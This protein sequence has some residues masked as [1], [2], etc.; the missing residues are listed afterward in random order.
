MIVR[1]VAQ[2]WTVVF[3]T[4]H[5]LLAQRIAS[6]LK[7]AR[8]LPFWFETQVAIGLHDDLHRVYE[9]G[10][11]EQLTE[12]GAPR[13]F[14]LVSM[15]DDERADETQAHIDEAFRKHSWL[16]VMQSKH[17]D[18]LYRG[19]DT[20]AEMQQLLDAEAKRREA[21]LARLRIE[22]SLVQDTYDWMHFC[23]RF[24][25][26]LCGNDVPAMHRRLEIITNHGGTRFELWQDDTDCIRVAPWPFVDETVELSVEYRTL[27]QLSYADDDELGKALKACPVE[28][29]TI[30]M[31]NGAS[32][33]AD[34]A[35]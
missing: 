17:A 9:K 21:T 22:P 27:R 1:S 35:D 13:D 4:T 3:H 20:T 25:L 26:I 24:S 6:C 18:T 19:E 31:S 16:G 23:D 15:K 12:A 2:G 8:S 32:V 34:H 7:A 11:Q 10:K 33:D 28:L 29:R 5:G 14:T 30:V